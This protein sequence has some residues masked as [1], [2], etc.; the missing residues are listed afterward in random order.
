MLVMGGGC[1]DQFQT[2]EIL[3][4]PGID[5]LGETSDD[6]GYPLRKWIQ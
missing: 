4:A 2:T 5:F 6:V 3:N 1:P